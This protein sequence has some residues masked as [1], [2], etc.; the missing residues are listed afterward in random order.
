MTPGPFRLVGFDDAGRPVILRSSTRTPA[1]QLEA[2][3]QAQ[4]R[5]ASLHRWQALAEQSLEQLEQLEAEAQAEAQLEQL[6]QRAA[7]ADCPLTW[8]HR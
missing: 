6:E 3:A 4:A 5:R 1:E 8:A 7:W 2:Q